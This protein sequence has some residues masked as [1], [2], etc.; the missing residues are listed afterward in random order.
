M[1]ISRIVLASNYSIFIVAQNKVEIDRSV[2]G[3]V[4]GVCGG[5]IEIGQDASINAN[6]MGCPRDKGA[7]TITWNNTCAGAGASYANNGGYGGMVYNIDYL[8]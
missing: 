2:T 1:N 8:K 5:D 6:G 7:G 4:I 3:S